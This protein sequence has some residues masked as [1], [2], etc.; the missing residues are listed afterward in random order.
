[1]PIHGGT[2]RHQGKKFGDASGYSVE[3]VAMEMSEERKLRQLDDDKVFQE[4][5]KAADNA[6][7]GGL[8]QGAK[9]AIGHLAGYLAHSCIHN[10]KYEPCLDLLV[11]KEV[12]LDQAKA[13]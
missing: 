6:D 4:L 10:H 7:S 2:G 3:N 11:N 8:E 1:M 5:T 12:L 9:Q 13:H